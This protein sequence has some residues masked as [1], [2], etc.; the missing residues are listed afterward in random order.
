MKKNSKYTYVHAP[1]VTAEEIKNLAYAGGLF[2][3]EGCIVMG[4]T[5]KFNPVMKKY[6]N[7]TTI[8]MEVCNTDFGLI[9]WLYD[10]FKEGHIIDLPP[11]KVK[12]GMSKPQKR[13]QLTHQQAYRVLKKLLPY[14]KEQNKIGKAKKVI[15]YYEEKR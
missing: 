2:D 7:C 8:R 5:M 15:N 6:Y 3:G 14:M 4:K 11:R 12:H 9:H 10:F 13:W 1:S